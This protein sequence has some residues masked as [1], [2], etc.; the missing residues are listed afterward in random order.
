M[1]T[2]I[3]SVSIHIVI[4]AINHHAMGSSLGRVTNGIAD[5]SVHGI[6]ESVEVKIM[7]PAID[8]K[9]S[10]SLLDHGTIWSMGLTQRETNG[11][12]NRAWES[13]EGV[14][15]RPTGPVVKIVGLGD[16]DAMRIFSYSD[17]KAYRS[18]DALGISVEV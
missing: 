5:G 16:E 4:H 17:G 2:M 15:V 13:K 9:I 3:P 1:A 11:S 14:V 8:V 10:V 7:L 18:D 12:R 6:R